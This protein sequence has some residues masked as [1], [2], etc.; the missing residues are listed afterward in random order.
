[1]TAPIE[2]LRYAT[3]RT[4]VTSGGVQTTDGRVAIKEEISVIRRCHLAATVCYVIGLL[5]LMFLSD[6]SRGSPRGV[7][8]W[9]V[10][11]S[12][13]PEVKPLSNFPRVVMAFMTLMFAVVLRVL[14]LYWTRRDESSLS[15]DLSQRFWPYTCFEFSTLDIFKTLLVLELTGEKDPSKH[16]MLVTL[17]LCSDV[18]K[19]TAE[20]LARSEIRSTEL[21]SAWV[22]LFFALPPFFVA[23]A[24]MFYQMS[25]SRGSFSTSTPWDKWMTALPALCF[26]CE[27]GL[28]LSAVSRVWNRGSEARRVCAETLIQ[29]A[30]VLS[31][32]ISLGQT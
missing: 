17:V 25:L 26:L 16:A 2:A 30:I 13:A 32:C 21:Q 5:V 9:P 20:S 11:D 7:V 12:L 10:R 18:F 31:L 8:Y 29:S 6:T 15:L 4:N 14:Y 27:T 22:M 28:L 23:W 1:M 3:V 24:L 19:W